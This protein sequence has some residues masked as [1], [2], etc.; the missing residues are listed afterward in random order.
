MINQFYKLRPGYELV[1]TK[2]RLHYWIHPS[3]CLGDIFP[4]WGTNL[5]DT[6]KQTFESGVSLYN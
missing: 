2:V 5:L 1:V 4:H 3:G 6:E